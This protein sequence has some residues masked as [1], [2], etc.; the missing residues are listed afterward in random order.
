M[1]VDIGNL[2]GIPGLV[3]MVG[4]D[5][6]EQ[7]GL[8]GIDMGKEMYIEF[9]VVEHTHKGTVAHGDFQFLASLGH[10]WWL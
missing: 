8:V 3:G 6:G 10:E 4:L 9:T 5:V 1:R 2:I 7:V